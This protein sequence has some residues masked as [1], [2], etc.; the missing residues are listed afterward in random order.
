MW[1]FFWFQC[2]HPHSLMG[3]INR[4]IVIKRGGGTRWHFFA[5][6]TNCRTRK[7]TNQENRPKCHPCH[8]SGSDGD[9]MT[10]PTLWPTRRPILAAPNHRHATIR[11]CRCGSITIGGLD[12]DY[13]AWAVNADLTPLTYPGELGA[14]I[15][16][17]RRTFWLFDRKL[18]RRN[19]WQ[20]TSPQRDPVLPEHVCDNPVP[21]DW[22]A[23]PT[24]TTRKAVPDDCPF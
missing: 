4:V 20:L 9:P 22:L 8:P 24:P 6:I 2:I 11:T 12:D 21:A 13:C 3:K 1:H 17:G 16:Q 15:S 5:I 10:Q 23:P 19:R 14:A 18:W 7:E